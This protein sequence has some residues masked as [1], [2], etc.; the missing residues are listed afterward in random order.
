MNLEEARCA[1][2]VRRDLAIRLVGTE[3][4]DKPLIDVGG[5]KK[6]VGDALGYFGSGS[7]QLAHNVRGNTIF[8]S[9]EALLPEEQ[10]LLF[11]VERAVRTKFKNL[12]ARNVPDEI[13]RQKLRDEDVSL[14]LP[15]DLRER[16]RGKNLQQI[17]DQ[18]LGKNPRFEITQLANNDYIGL[19]HLGS[20]YLGTASLNGKNPSNEIRQDLPPEILQGPLS[21]LEHTETGYLVAPALTDKPQDQQK[22]TVQDSLQNN[23][24]TH[25]A[26]G[27]WGSSAIHQYEFAK[28]PRLSVEKFLKRTYG[29]RNDQSL[30]YL[31]RIYV[32]DPRIGNLREAKVAAN[33]RI[34]F[35]EDI[36][37]SGTPLPGKNR[38]VLKLK[39]SLAPY[40]V[41]VFPLLKNKPEL[42]EKAKE[43]F[44]NLSE[45]FETMW[46]DR[47]NIGKR[48]LYQDEIGTPFCVTVDFESLDDDAVTVRDRDTA[49]QERVP[50]ADLKSF[51]SQR[52]SP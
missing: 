46:D 33:G 39:P 16:Y 13:I 3:L 47:G 8:K 5:E 45:K 34:Y 41:A 42:V 51:L 28:D 15:P 38:I 27:Y 12:K 14:S 11:E 40:K 10:R 25:S 21:D 7:W 52:L 44:N 49:Q 30:Q 43:V 18:I 37:S 36:G 22:Y 2:F 26:N 6:T 4:A 17:H 32:E 9:E 20:K 29:L 24:H 19:Y 1:E 23:R 31:G 50:I 35:V 48:Y